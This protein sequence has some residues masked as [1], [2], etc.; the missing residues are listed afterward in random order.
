MTLQEF[1]SALNEWGK[2]KTPFFFC[3]DF[4]LEKPFAFALSD[5]NNHDVL[6][7][8]NGFSNGSYAA[9]S[10][11]R[12][13]LTKY[14]ISFSDYKYKFDR[15]FQ[16]LAYGDSFLTNLTVKTRIET[17]HAMSALFH[18]ANAKY[19][20]LVKEKFL[21][22]SPETFV[23]I[24]DGKIFSYPMKGTIDASILNAAEVIINDQKERAEHITIVDL[25]RND[26]SL[27][28]QNVHVSKFRFIEEIKTNNKNLLQVSSEI[29]GTL[30]RN[31]R[32]RL[33]DILVSL[34]PAGSISGAPKQKTLEII[35]EAEKEKRGYYTG[36]FG[37]FDGSVLDSAVMIRFIEQ[38]GNQ[39]YYRSGGGITTQ[40]DAETEYQE[41]IDKV[42]V[43]VT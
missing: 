26:L 7:N 17:D 28:S 16:R 36:V 32:E 12:P 40:S 14:P 31:Y 42:Y 41:A 10:A 30:P 15:V 11:T 43:P 20:L 18:A 38:V 5:S 13:T 2:T 19:K 27:V 24:R 9:H 39:L 21:V 23:R 1:K 35:S 4:E 29:T 33:G 3:I 6:F 37:Y 34:L 8:I 22:F 25:I